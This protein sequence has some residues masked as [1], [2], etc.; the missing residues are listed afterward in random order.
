MTERDSQRVSDDDPIDVRRIFLLFWRRRM[1]IVLSIVACGVLGWATGWITPIRYEATARLFASSQV[2]T[3]APSET[4]VKYQALA[5]EQVVAADVIKERGLDRPPYNLTVAGF[6]SSVRSIV[7]PPNGIVIKVTLIDPLEAA[8]IGGTIAK[9]VVAL[10]AE[11]EQQAAIVENQK[12]ANIQSELATA[13]RTVA[14][15]QRA[16]AKYTLANLDRPDS[17]TVVDGAAELSKLRTRIEAARAEVRATE[18]YLSRTP[19]LIGLGQRKY[20]DGTA[21]TDSA[22]IQNPTFSSVSVLVAKSRAALAGLEARHAFLLAAFKNA[23]LGAA[24]T[25][26]MGS[27][28]ELARLQGTLAE[29][30]LERD[31]INETLQQTRRAIAAPKFVLQQVNEEVQPGEPTGSIYVRALFGMVAGLLLALVAVVLADLITDGRR[32]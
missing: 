12:I 28:Y 22:M 29:A 24:A 6:R 16:L 20:S 1:A 14:D 17:K 25:K 31:R 8:V 3:P 27:E 7:M 26:E 4:L 11:R 10:A 18:A 23:T 13:E 21:E 9:R 32:V 5:T 15:A 30:R 19:P 2:D